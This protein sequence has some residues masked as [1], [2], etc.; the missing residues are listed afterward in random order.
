MINYCSENFKVVVVFLKLQVFK[1][2]VSAFAEI[3]GKSDGVGD[4]LHDGIHVARVAQIL[5]ARQPASL[6]NHSA[7]VILHIGVRRNREVN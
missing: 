2:P 3:L 7:K 1:L 4:T 6:E 5:E